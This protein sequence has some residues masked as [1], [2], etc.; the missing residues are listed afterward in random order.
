MAE[1]TEQ[2]RFLL[3]ECVQAYFWLA[4]PAEVQEFEALVQHE[5]YREVSGMATTWFE[6]GLEKGLEEGLE[7]QRQLLLIMIE[8]R[9]GSLAT[10]ARDEL[11]QWPAEQLPDLARKIVHAQSLRDLGIGE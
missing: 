10:A 11:M 4:E 6:E 9:F 7:A 1:L 2:Q 8:E 3:A 5:P